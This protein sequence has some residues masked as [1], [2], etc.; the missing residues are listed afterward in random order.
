MLGESAVVIF[1]V[2]C[3][4]IALLCKEYGTKVILSSD[5]HINTS[6]GNFSKGIELFNKINMPEELIMNEPDKLIA[7][8]KNKG[9]LQDL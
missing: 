2:N 9:R 1:S 4:K 8:L 5:A 7:H 3:K 6:I